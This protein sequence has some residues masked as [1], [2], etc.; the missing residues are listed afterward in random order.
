LDFGCGFSFF[1]L[2]ILLIIVNIIDEFTRECLRIK[3]QRNISSQD[4]IEE[5]FN[6]FIFRGMP[7]HNRSDNGSMVRNLPPGQLENGLINWE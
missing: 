1:S 7:E 3:V 5:L 4:V 2:F 6:L